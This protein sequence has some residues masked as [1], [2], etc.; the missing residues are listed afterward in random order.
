MEI[1]LF[2]KAASEFGLNPAD[3]FTTLNNNAYSGVSPNWNDA[4]NAAIAELAGGGTVYLPAGMY[5]FPVS[6]LVDTPI[7]LKGDNRDGTSILTYDTHGIQIEHDNVV[8]SDL[9][10]RGTGNI[11]VGIKVSS[12][13]AHLKRVT[14]DR[15]NIGIWLAG[16]SWYMVDC[17]SQNNHIYGFYITGGGGSAISANARENGSPMNSVP[18]TAIPPAFGFYD[19][20]AAVNVYIGCHSNIG[21]SLAPSSTKRYAGDFYAKTA[22]LIGCYT[23]SG[24]AVYLYDKSLLMNGYIGS[25][26]GNG[27]HI[28]GSAYLIQEG[29]KGIKFEN[30][31][32]PLNIVDFTA[33]SQTAG[34]IFEFGAERDFL[35]DTA[36]EVIIGVG[37]KIGREVP[38][39]AR[40]F[41]E[42]LS[43][44]YQKEAL[45]FAEIQTIYGKL[46]TSKD[47]KEQK[48]LREKVD[49]LT[50]QIELFHKNINTLSKELDTILLPTGLPTG[51]INIESFFKNKRGRWRLRYDLDNSNYNTWYKL[52]YSSTTKS[53]PP[54]LAF[55]S[56]RTT[57]ETDGRVIERGSVGFPKGYYL[58]SRVNRTTAIHVTVSSTIPTHS[59]KPGDRVFN[60]NPNDDGNPNN[61]QNCAGWI[62]LGELNWKPFSIH[63]L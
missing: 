18:L 43:I 37:G 50:K 48:L 53:Y 11:F 26:K 22:I 35:L 52:E 7:H 39:E 33:G 8:I 10:V 46:S 34:V 42:E 36:N 24:G 54:A 14:V 62:C 30:R 16:S 27:T 58:G 47:E 45:L 44:L 9:F 60:N 61:P 57:T 3:V 23:E 55:S 40:K 2:E 4:Y 15:F 6:I 29:H 41:I 32:F 28:M 25:I 21:D 5:Q 13:H 31:N 59:G 49:T 38:V 17:I 1:N 12:S 20:S 56:S 63:S 51:T 19:K